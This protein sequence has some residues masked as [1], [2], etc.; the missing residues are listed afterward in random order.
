M[1]LIHRLLWGVVLCAGGFGAIV[2]GI[3]RLPED[4]AV[5]SASETAPSE[6]AE[7]AEPAEAAAP[8]SAGEAPGKAAANKDLRINEAGLAIIKE[9]EGLRLEAYAAGGRWYIGYGHA[10][11]SPGQTITEAEADK[12]LRQDLR[13]SEE[14]VRGL[15]AVPVNEN[16][17]SAMVSLCYN[18]GEG[19]F[20]RSDVVERLNAGDRKGA[21]DAFLNHNR[22]G[23]V[24]NDH[25][26][27]RREKERALFLTPA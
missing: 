18:L 22:A 11:A 13:G 3:D 19:N 16:E 8:A 20:S 7:Q 9:S 21:A 12:L 14:A 27:A 15:I 10:G 24:P 23:G 26:T 5:T 25:L 6:Q 1:A 2:F 17:F 4:A